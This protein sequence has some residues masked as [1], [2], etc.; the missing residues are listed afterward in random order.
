VCG[1]FR[2]VLLDL[3]E[4]VVLSLITLLF[5][6]ENHDSLR[7]GKI[8]L[9]PGYF[10]VQNSWILDYMKSLIESSSYL[11]D[12]LRASHHHKLLKLF[13]LPMLILLLESCEQ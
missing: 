2:D 10:I 13:H 5:L 1:L 6:L 7:L 9:D 3:L 12:P 8:E 11:D 4:S